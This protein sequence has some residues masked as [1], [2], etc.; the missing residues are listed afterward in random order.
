MKK[1]RGVEEGGRTKGELWEGG[2]TEPRGLRNLRVIKEARVETKASSE[3]TEISNRDGL[4]DCSIKV[5]SR[6]V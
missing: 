1:I 5:V 6:K 3:Q 4:E 2:V